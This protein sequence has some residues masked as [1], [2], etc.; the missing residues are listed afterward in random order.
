MIGTMNGREDNISQTST[1][2]IIALLC[3]LTL[4]LCVCVPGQTK[5]PIG[6]TNS[7]VVS[8]L[9]NMPD[10]LRKEAFNHIKAQEWQAA[11]DKFKKVNAL[12]PDDG[13]GFYGI[14]L[15]YLNLGK[16]EAADATIKKAIGKIDRTVNG[17][18]LAD[19][20]VLSGV[21][22][23]VR[24]EMKN[25]VESLKIALEIAPAHFDAIF[26]M[27]RALFGQGDLKG[28][29]GYFEKAVALQ[30]LNTNARFFYGT[31]LE[32]LDDSKGALVQYKKILEINSSDIRGNLGL[33][34]L[35]LKEDG[36]SSKEGIE[37]LRRVISNDGNNYEARV[38]LGKVLVQKNDFEEAIEH[39]RIA[40]EMA[41]NNPEPHFQLSIAYRRLGKFEESK[42]EAQRVKMIHE[43]R[44]KISNEP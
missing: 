8:D 17:S 33:G 28:S 19:A 41:P 30:P 13:L 20:Y 7:R 21:I 37:A 42:R 39:L 26:T 6:D 18:L 1:W 5:K 14:S 15:A 35:L 44:R 25:A 2:T 12:A 10:G 31:V 23:S 24:K 34:V 9:S 32:R 3:C 4:F 36:G 29:A 40:A 16:I 43:K 27:A 22:S 38:T 11:V